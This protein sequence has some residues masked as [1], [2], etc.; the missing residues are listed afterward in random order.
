VANFLVLELDTSPPNINILAPNYTTSESAIDIEVVS[1][2]TLSDSFQSFYILDAYGK[3]YDYIFSYDGNKYTGR[4][5]LSGFRNGLVTFYAQVKDEVHNLSGIATKV[6]EVIP[7]VNYLMLSLEDKVISSEIDSGTI[8]QD[9]LS[10][11]SGNSSNVD[12]VMRISER[13]ISTELSNREVLADIIELRTITG[14]K[15][16]K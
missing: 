6:I 9:I 8:Q 10:S 7:S 11:I 3:R 4:I 2:E 13:D 1:D 12:M 15:V 16:V 5:T 14:T